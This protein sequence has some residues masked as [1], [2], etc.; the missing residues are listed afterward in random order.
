MSIKLSKTEVVLLEN[1]CRNS[2]NLAGLAS[3][4]G[5]KLSFASRVVKSLEGKGML[6]SNRGAEG[7]V[8]EL[9]P[10]SHAQAFKELY[11]SR[12]NAGIEA[13]LSG[14]ALDVLASIGEGA[15]VERLE[16]ECSCSRP[17]IFRILKNLKSAGVLAKTSF[18]YKVSDEWVSRFAREYAANIALELAESF[19]GESTVTSIRKHVLV[20]NLR[21]KA[22]AFAH[23]TGLRALQKLGLQVIPTD[24]K[25]YY[26][27]LDGKEH[28]LGAEENVVHALVLAKTPNFAAD[29]TAIAIFLKQNRQ[30]NYRKLKRLAQD[31]GVE[32]L[33]QEMRTAVGYYEKMR[34]YE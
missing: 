6:Q 23:E 7:K 32:Q 30:L 5:L 8:I 13:W 20:R 25:E 28:E 18:G 16:R 1:A 12:P 15:S 9:S 10:A 17:T 21:G 14:K 11:F 4:S 31:Y 26:F 19:G 3:A 27:N 24:Y 22:P 29:Q 2:G 34:E 33:L